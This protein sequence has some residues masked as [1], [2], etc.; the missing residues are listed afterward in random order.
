[1]EIQFGQVRLVQYILENKEISNGVYMVD[2]ESFIKFYFRGRDG[3]SEGKLR[4]IA[5]QPSISVLVGDK[6]EQTKLFKTQNDVFKFVTIDLIP[7]SKNTNLRQYK[8]QRMI[9]F[10]GIVVKVDDIPED[11]S[12]KF[13]NALSIMIKD[14]S[15]KYLINFFNPNKIQ[16]KNYEGLGEIGFDERRKEN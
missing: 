12:F 14:F 1:M 11:I 5:G 13:L 6:E 9:P 2:D 8:P 4:F 7:D 16:E 10:E 15:F 3:Y